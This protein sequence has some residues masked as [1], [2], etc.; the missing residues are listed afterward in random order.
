MLPGFSETMLLVK[1]TAVVEFLHQ[2]HAVTPQLLLENSRL[3]S[4]LIVGITSV[5]LSVPNWPSKSPSKGCGQLILS[6]LH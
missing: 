6:F 4:L 2:A 3:T 1:A 5:V